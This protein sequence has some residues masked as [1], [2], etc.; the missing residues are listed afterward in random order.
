MGGVAGH[1]GLFSTVDDIMTFSTTL[2]DVWHGRSDVWPQKLV[3]EFTRRQDL[4]VGSD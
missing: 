4:P 3:K 2:L 1:A